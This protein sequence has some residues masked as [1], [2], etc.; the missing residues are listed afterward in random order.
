MRSG[1]SNADVSEADRGVYE[2]NDIANSFYRNAVKLDESGRSIEAL[3]HYEKSAEVFREGLKRAASSDSVLVVE[4]KTK[5]ANA[6]KRYHEIRSEQV[7]QRL[8]QTTQQRSLLLYDNKGGGAQCLGLR[9]GDRGGSMVSRAASPPPRFKRADSKCRTDIPSFADEVSRSSSQGSSPQKR[10]AANSNSKSAADAGGRSDA[11]KNGK[12][13]VTWDDIAGLDVAKRSLYES[14]ILP[15]QR[16]DLFT[17]L[18]KPPRAILL[19]GPPGTGKT[20]LAKA[21]ASEAGLNFASVTS[22][23][24]LSKWVGESEKNVREMFE[25][26]KKFQPSVLFIDEVDA[27]LSSRTEGETDAT[28]RMKNEFLVQMDGAQA[29]LT[30]KD[31]VLIVAATNRPYD[32]DDAALRRFPKRIY[33]PLPEEKARAALISHLIQKNDN[34]LTQRD[35]EWIVR[36]TAGFSGSDLASLC[37]EAAMI[38]VRELDPSKPIDLL[39]I[40]PISCADFRAAMQN[41]KPTVSRELLSRFEAWTKSYGMSGV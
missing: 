21:L 27:L 25:L 20:M 11:E 18:R 14:A 40:R 10:P 1:S 4:M 15:M 30:E 2:F 8:Q 36:S 12:A 39:A 13:G 34:D 22:S 32:L 9:S 37:A 23:T 41:I 35:L 28:R 31:K 17:G 7:P 5:A 24:L 16:P 38:A 6:E 26:A 19:Y 33:I 29:A 3:K